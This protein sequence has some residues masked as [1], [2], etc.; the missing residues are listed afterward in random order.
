MRKHEKLTSLLSWIILYI[1]ITL[2]FVFLSIILNNESSHKLPTEIL[3]GWILT[4]KC[5]TL[6][7]SDRDIIRAHPGTGL[8]WARD[9]DTAV[10]HC[11][12]LM[13]DGDCSAGLHLLQESWCWVKE[14]GGER[15]L[16]TRGKVYTDIDHI[17][18][19]APHFSPVALSG[20]Y[21]RRDI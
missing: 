21:S 14:R 3:A 18:F 10:L 17:Q 2:I 6:P 1:V 7:P 11:T 15:D 5:Q 16:G 9:H 20:S 8:P 19:P 13:A 12:G 4:I